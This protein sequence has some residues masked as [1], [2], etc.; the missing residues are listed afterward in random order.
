[1]NPII[2]FCVNNIASGS[3]EA[4][5]KLKKILRWTSLNMDV[6]AIAGFVLRFYLRL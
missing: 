4:F 2:E 1:M 5:E 3:Q 6:P